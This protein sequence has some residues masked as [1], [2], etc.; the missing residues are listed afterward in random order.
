MLTSTFFLPPS[1]II[2]NKTKQ[3][4][5]LREI[6]ASI[7]PAIVTKISSHTHHL[8]EPPSMSNSDKQLTKKDILKSINAHIRAMDWSRIADQLRIVKFDK[9]SSVAAGSSGV[10]AGPGYDLYVRKDVECQRRYTKLVTDLVTP[11]TTNPSGDTGGTGST[12]SGNG[13]ARK[14]STAT[15]SKSGNKEMSK[16]PW[17]AEEDQKVVDL[18]GKY[19]P[20]K[21]SQIANELP[22]EFYALLRVSLRITLTMICS[23]PPKRIF[24]SLSLSL[25][26]YPSQKQKAV[27]ENNVVNDGTI[28]SI[29]TSPRHHGLKMKTVSS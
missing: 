10:V 17:S 11:P 16:G 24:L 18:V 7:Y 20:K 19:G 1:L 28:I 13:S 3:D 25:A 2:Y 4:E 29:L 22:G 14:R 27:L 5:S 21:W 8:A 9:A 26:V 15:Y 6:V 12:P 23:S